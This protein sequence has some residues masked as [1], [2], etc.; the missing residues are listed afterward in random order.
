MGN[1]IAQR[2]ERGARQIIID[3]GGTYRNVM[4]ALS[5][6]DFENTYFESLKQTWL[7]VQKPV[8]DREITSIRVP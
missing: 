6:Q 5:G 2:L 1:F 3:K 7:L 4:Y 8:R